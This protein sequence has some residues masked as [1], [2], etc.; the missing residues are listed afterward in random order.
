MRSTFVIRYSVYIIITIAIIIIIIIMLGSA[1]LLIINTVSRVQIY[2]P[3]RCGLSRI[4]AEIRTN[5]H[6]EFT[7]DVTSISGESA[8]ACLSN[9]PA[10][11]SGSYNR[12]DVAFRR[13][14]R[15]LGKIQSTRRTF[16][17]D[18]LTVCSD[19]YKVTTE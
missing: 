16:A 6:A 1:K 3:H 13:R 19:M 10:L 5:R 18:D 4:S 8:N 14:A 12:G 7:I 11:I 2:H 9:V 17:L 15:D